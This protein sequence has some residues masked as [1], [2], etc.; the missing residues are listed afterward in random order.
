[1]YIGHEESG[2]ATAQLLD[3]ISQATINRSRR[4]RMIYASFGWS[5]SI[6]ST[7]ARARTAGA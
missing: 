3:A 6:V 1:L 5:G 4:I 2:S 7:N